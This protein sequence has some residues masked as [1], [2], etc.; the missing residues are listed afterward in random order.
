[1]GGK[2]SGRDPAGTPPEDEH[3]VEAIGRTRVVIRHGKVVEVGGPLIRDCPLARRFAVPVTDFTPEAIRAN[4]EHRIASFGMC[5][6]ARDL[7]SD[8][9]FVLFGASELLSTA[10][11]AGLVSAVV[12]ACDGAGTVVVTRPDLVQGIGG[13][14]S[15]LAR[16]SPIREVIAGIRSLG[17]EVLDPRGGTIDMPSGADLA[18]VRGHRRFAVTVA[19]S[20]DAERIRALHPRAVIFAVHTT[21]I[22][23]EEAERLVR[24]CDLVTSCASRHL[25][26]LGA[27]ALL[28]AGTAIPVFAFT[29]AGKE[30][31][32]SKLRETA[33]P[34]LVKGERLPV[35]GGRGSPDPLV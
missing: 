30:V 33:S 8:R 17:G 7:L 12:L 14:M 6:P 34:L 26:D 11:R 10:L 2:G 13:R 19:S 23:R 9:D 1:M 3:V 27:G 18:A 16:T 31:I 32:L 35:A 28:Q 20:A 22:S 25:R 29:P 15:G 24:A 4:I 21:G 5:T